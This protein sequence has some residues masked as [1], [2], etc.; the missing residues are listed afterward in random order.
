M[1]ILAI[2]IFLAPILFVALLFYGDE[3]VGPT[4]KTRRLLGSGSILAGLGLVAV[5][6]VGSRTMGYQYSSFWTIIFGSSTLSGCQ[7]LMWGAI[8]HC[9]PER[10][11]WLLEKFF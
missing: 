6:F 2:N 5:V 8:L 7:L 10:Q 9:S 3:G 11:K 1:E 4:V